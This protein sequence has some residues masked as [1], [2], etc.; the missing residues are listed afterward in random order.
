ML[1]IRKRAALYR[2]PHWIKEFSWNRTGQTHRRAQKKETSTKTAKRSK[3]EELVNLQRE[4]TD[5]QKER[6]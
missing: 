6:E 1:K 3:A 4:G 2:N 5:I